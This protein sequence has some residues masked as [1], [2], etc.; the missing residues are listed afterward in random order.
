MKNKRNKKLLSSVLMALSLSS[1]VSINN[2]IANA[3]YKNIDRE[4]LNS[5]F[6]NTNNKDIGSELFDTVKNIRKHRYDNNQS[7]I[8]YNSIVGNS[9]N[10]FLNNEEN[11]K[12]Y[13]PDLC[14]ALLYQ[15]RA[16]HGG[17]FTVWNDEIKSK[18]KDLED[19][20][21]NEINC[22]DAWFYALGGTQENIDEYKK[23]KEK[24]KEVLNCQAK[25]EK[26]IDSQNKAFS[27]LNLNDICT[28]NKDV[29]RTWPGIKD[30]NVNKKK[31]ILGRILK[32]Y[33]LEKSNYLQG[34]NDWGAIII[35][36][37]VGCKNKE[38]SEETEAKIYYVYKTIMDELC[39]FF[40]T[41]SLLDANDKT[42]EQ[43]AKKKKSDLCI[44]FRNAFIENH[45][46]STLPIQL[47]DYNEGD[48]N[49][50]NNNE[51]VLAY[52]FLGGFRCLE[53]E[54]KIK[55]LDKMIYGENSKVKIK[56][57]PQKMFDEVYEA[58][59]INDKEFEIKENTVYKNAYFCILN[60]LEAKANQELKFSNDIQ[61]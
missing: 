12:H 10:N 7:S 55:L 44:G 24:F 27:G 14:K 33:D 32:I 28:I 58:I 19:K 23:D 45:K 18:I 48:I 13:G 35:D 49:N 40:V 53:R 59:I 30:I 4:R 56:E 51:N 34:G 57:L 36:K 52:S 20:F 15:L 9:I 43:K 1:S 26:Q 21:C 61:N 11:K 6:T 2:K 42:E 46:N 38:I 39:E 8:L 29:P 41:F 31:E 5:L 22:C 37:F 60:Y 50:I 16:V 25:D 54:L 17:H 47:T 3:N